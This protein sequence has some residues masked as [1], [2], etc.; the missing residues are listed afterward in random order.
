MNVFGLDIGSTSTKIIQVEKSGDKYRLLAAGIV[1]TPMPGLSSEAD[2]D[3]AALSTALKKL[4]SDAHISTKK[5]VTALSENDV[6]AK[7]IDLPPMKESEL[8]ESIPYEAERFIPLPLSEV[9]LDWKILN[10]GGK[11]LGGVEQMKVFLAAAP[12]TV[13][14]KYLKVLELAGFEIAA[15]ETEVIA[16]A[17]ALL[18][19]TT[20]PSMLID[21]G[22]KTTDLAIVHNGQVLMT[23]SLPTAGEAFTRAISSGLS[24]DLTQAE[25]YKRAYGLKTNQL[26]GKI[27]TSLAP[28]FE[29]VT[30]EIKKAIAFWNEKERNNPVSNIIL[31]GGTAN[32]PEATS[33]ITNLL[34]VEVQI[35]DPFAN[36]TA[37]EQIMSSLRGNACMFSVAVGLAQKEL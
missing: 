7:I 25:E 17:R 37:S 13:V 8:A 30:A 11:A 1:P 35:A 10:K 29:V 34:G 14:E 18:P 2:S 21:F 3:L 23:R 16:A 27:K 4:H 26:E 12:K 19:Q 36:V 24:L 5:V 9:S 32:L 31:S 15:M 22:A 33:T 28:V 20:K 6:F